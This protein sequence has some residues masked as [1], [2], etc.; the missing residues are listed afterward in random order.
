MPWALRAGEVKKKKNEIAS[1]RLAPSIFSAPH[2]GAQ[3]C[4]GLFFETLHFFLWAA[5]VPPAFFLSIILSK[6]KK[7]VVDNMLLAD[8]VR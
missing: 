2:S 5:L 8:C 4:A 3:S 1:S 6:R 7:S